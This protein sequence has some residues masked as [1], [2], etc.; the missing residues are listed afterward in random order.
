[1]AVVAALVTLAAGCTAALVAQPNLVLSDE[2]SEKF[3]ALWVL[4]LVPASI[5][6]VGY[7]VASTARRGQTYGK[8]CMGI[9][10]VPRRVER[11][12]LRLRHVGKG[13]WGVPL[14]ASDDQAALSGGQRCLER[15]SSLVRWAV[16]H[17]AGLLAAVVAGGVSRDQSD[18]GFYMSVAG[19]GLAAWLLVYASSLWDSNRRGWHDKAAGTIVVNVPEPQPHVDR[20]EGAAHEP[21]SGV[22][23]AG[24]EG[25]GQTWGMVSDYY[26]PQRPDAAQGRR[27]KTT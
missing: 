8:R 23:G 18:G 15:Y 27:D 9:Q 10:V 7:E 3:V 26:G 24:Q 6:V 25:S 11:S 22:A 16:P 17:G 19:A 4:L 12:A 20:P 14:A 13:L 1:M 5:P 2:N 21:R